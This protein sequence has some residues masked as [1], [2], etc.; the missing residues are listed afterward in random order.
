MNTIQTWV[1]QKKV[2]NIDMNKIYYGNKEMKDWNV[3]K[4]REIINL[5][6][7]DKPVEDDLFY[8]YTMPYMKEQEICEFSSKLGFIQDYH[9]DK[10]KSRFKYMEDLIDYVI[11]N[12]KINTFFEELIK[13]KRFRIINT[14]ATANFYDANTIYWKII[15]GFFYS[16]NQILFFDEC[17]LEYDLDVY[18]F[19]LVDNNKEISLRA[20]KIEKV[21][22]QYIKNLKN[23]IDKVVKMRDYESAITKSRTMI[24][25]VL[26][27]G[28]EEKGEKP[29]E[30]GNINNLYNQFKTLYNMHQD[31]MLDKRINSLLSG[32]EKIITA[33]S[34]MRD[35]NSDSHGVG[36][37]RITIEEYHVVLFA[38]SAITMS[39]F[40]LSVI[41]N[42]SKI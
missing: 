21:G 18:E 23:Q 14:D 7:G 15:N 25:E 30:K 29:L 22:R 5:I 39:N 8:Q 16:I 33:I 36:E 9:K 42:K 12:N 19:S 26:V 4:D 40:L 10:K 11:K 24:E 13:L 38:N 6:I 31:K 37:K 27:L 2:K 32:L 35:K 41:E 17:H 20:E 28:I 34:Q 3:L 1:L